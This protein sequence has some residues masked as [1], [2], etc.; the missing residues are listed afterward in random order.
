MIIKNGYIRGVIVSGGGFNDLGVPVAATETLTDPIACNI[1]YSSDKQGEATQ[2][3]YRTMQATI[4]IEPC[5]DW[6]KFDEVIVT[7]TAGRELGKYVVQS[8]V[9][10]DYVRLIEFKV[11]CR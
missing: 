7:D 8:S 3:K 4:R 6:K 10:L 9:L 1:S 2:T 5:D 11:I